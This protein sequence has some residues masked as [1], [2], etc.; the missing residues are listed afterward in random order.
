MN[1]K[2]LMV[3]MTSA[4]R[5]EAG[6]IAEELLRRRLAACVS[7]F[8]KG[9]SYFWWEGT[10]D[11]EEEYLLIAKTGAGRF[12]DLVS[13]VKKIHGYEVPE[14]VSVPLTGGNPDYLRWLDEEI[15]DEE[16]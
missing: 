2:Y 10:I 15:G 1:S 7:I 8:P 4:D 11:R 12:A 3:F 14:I 5:D 9:E 16:G 6:K 13:S